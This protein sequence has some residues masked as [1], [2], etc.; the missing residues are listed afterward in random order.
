MKERVYPL[1]TTGGLIQGQVRHGDILVH[2]GV[3]HGH[4]SFLLSSSI[5][6]AGWEINGITTPCWLVC[7]FFILILSILL[8]YG[9]FPGFFICRGFLIFQ[10]VLLGFLQLG[11]L[12]F[13]YI[14]QTI[15]S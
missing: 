7:L 9:F 6:D 3:V 12:Y 14:I 4:R 5:H 1:D 10:G 11:V 13:F 2:Q 15:T 8:V